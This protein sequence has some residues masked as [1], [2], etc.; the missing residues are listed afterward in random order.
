MAVGGLALVRRLEA[1]GHEL[2]RAQDTGRSITS[3]DSI[4]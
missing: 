3:R 4:Y 2:G 1:H